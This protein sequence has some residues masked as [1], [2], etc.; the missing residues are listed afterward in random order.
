MQNVKRQSHARTVLQGGLRIERVVLVGLPA[1]PQGAQ[2][3]WYE[4]ATAEARFPSQVRNLSMTATSMSG[5]KSSW[6]L[7]IKYPAVHLGGPYNWALKL[8]F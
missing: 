1:A 7:T 3:L 5:D 2:L 8:W 4:D 6:L